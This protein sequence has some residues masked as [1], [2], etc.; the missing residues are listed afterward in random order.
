MTTGLVRKDCAFKHLIT[1]VSNI[2]S[3]ACQKTEAGN[4][5]VLYI[6]EVTK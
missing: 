2:N 6:L 3:A 5:V 1:T 4:T